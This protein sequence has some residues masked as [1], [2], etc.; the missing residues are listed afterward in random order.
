MTWENHGK[1][2]DKWHIDHI[3]PVSDFELNASVAEINALSNLRPLWE[4]ENLSL[5]G[6]Q[7]IKLRQERRKALK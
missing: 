5:G 4:R 1:G 2:P 7:S 6:K 3:R